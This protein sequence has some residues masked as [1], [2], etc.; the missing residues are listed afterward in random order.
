MQLQHNTRY[1]STINTISIHK[2]TILQLYTM[3]TSSNAELNPL[4]HKAFSANYYAVRQIAQTLPVSRQIPQLLSS[5]KRH[6]VVIFVGE[7]GSGKTTQLPK[8]LFQELR[9]TC[10]KKLALTQNR[11]LSTQLV[12][13]RIFTSCHSGILLIIARL[14][15]V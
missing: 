7:T 10:D 9:K 13:R 6:N 1:T 12:C 4:T 3:A 11:Q 2:F 5:I 14:V 15:N 8:A